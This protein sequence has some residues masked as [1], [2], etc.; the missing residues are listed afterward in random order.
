VSHSFSVTVTDEA[1]NVSSPAR[2]GWTYE[3]SPPPRTAAPFGSLDST[4]PVWNGVRLRGWAIDPDAGSQPIQVAVYRDPGPNQVFEGNLTADRARP[5]VGTAFP[6]D[7]PNHGFD[8]TIADALGTHTWC[9]YGINDSGTGPNTTLGCASATSTV[10]P[11][12]PIGSLDAAVVGSGPGLIQVSGWALDP[13]TTAPVTVA[14]Y[15]D[16]VGVPV[17]A[18]G[19]RPDV[20]AV[21]GDGADHGFSHVLHT[22][23]GPHQV[24]AY[25][26]NAVSTPG[27]T[28]L[29]GCKV[30]TVGGSPFGA[31][32]VVDP[33]PGGI[34]VA[35]WAI[36]P[37]APGPD[38]VAV[39]LD[40]VGTTSYANTP[41]PD[42]QMAYPGWGPLHGFDLQIAA[43]PGVHTVCVYAINTGPGDNTLLGYHTVT[44]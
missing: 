29:V 27:A 34:H 5:D 15:V 26:Y 38:T 23:A 2:A 16:K 21:F 19:A 14:L 37:D 11:G 8:V 32:D 31:L 7:G 6:G 9:A 13:D 3:T 44:V 25:A 30:V 40:G 22:V 35:G 24:C 4:A 39:Y 10:V 1:G 12:N 43:T 36:E 17:V 42:V 28:A 20:A 33:A 41:R 18:D